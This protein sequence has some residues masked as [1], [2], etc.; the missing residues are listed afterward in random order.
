MGK[1]VYVHGR[2]TKKYKD[3]NGDIFLG[4]IS[5]SQFGL[6]Q[7]PRVRHPPMLEGF[8][9]WFFT[10]CESIVQHLI[11][12][13]TSLSLSPSLYLSLSLLLT[14]FLSLSTLASTTQQPT[15]LNEGSVSYL[16]RFI[17]WWRNTT[18]RH[19][20]AQFIYINSVMSTFIDISSIDEYFHIHKQ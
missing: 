3:Y 6:H 12:H 13:H 9:V 20:V 18:G 1:L 10:Q 11:A 14:L 4:Y 7:G 2:E 5:L 16:K 19:S 15:R 8:P 17:I